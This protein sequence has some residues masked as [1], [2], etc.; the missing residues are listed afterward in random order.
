MRQGEVASQGKW[1]G[2]GL[3][4]VKAPEPVILPDPTKRFAGTA[5]RLEALEV[6]HPIEALQPRRCPLLLVWNSVW[7][8]R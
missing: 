7:S 1:A 5:R 2:T 3:G 6:G 8:S 4:G